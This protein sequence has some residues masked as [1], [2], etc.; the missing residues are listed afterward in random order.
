[1]NRTRK[2]P[3]CCPHCSKPILSPYHA[4][5]LEDVRRNPGSS[6]KR[7]WELASKRGNILLSCVQTR[8]EWLREH[9]FVK[10]EKGFSRCYRYTACK[11]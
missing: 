11:S 4:P 2:S 8:L 1:M 10:R 7:I 9:G 3:E 6:A 5:I